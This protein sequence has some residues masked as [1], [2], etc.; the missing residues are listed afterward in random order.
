MYTECLSTVMVPEGFT[1]ANGH[2][3]PTLDPILRADQKVRNLDFDIAATHVLKK[4]A[5]VGLELADVEVT[6]GRSPVL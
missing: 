4:L 3:P 5:H 1:P 6:Q 2:L